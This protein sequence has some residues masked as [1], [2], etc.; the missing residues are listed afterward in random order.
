MGRAFRRKGR[1]R[2]RPVSVRCEA[3]GAVGE[4][5]RC[6]GVLVLSELTKEG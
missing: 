3:K 5:G 2:L 4:K 1:W 6:D